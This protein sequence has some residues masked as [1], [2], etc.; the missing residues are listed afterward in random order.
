[1][2]N[3]RKDGTLYEADV[4]VLPMVGSDGAVRH[5]VYVERDISEAGRLERTTRRLMAL[6]SHNLKTPL[7]AIRWQAEMLR[8]GDV[9]R[10]SAPQ[11]ECVEDILGGI[12]RTISMVEQWF[13]VTKMDLGLYAFQNVPGDLN[14]A[15]RRVLDDLQQRIEQEGVTV[16]C[17]PGASP[18]QVIADSEALDTIVH[19]LLRNAVKYNR[20]GGTVDIDTRML[21]AHSE[22]A[23]KT[24]SDPRAI[25]SVRDS[26]IGIPHNEQGKV[27]HEFFHASNTNTTQAGGAGLGLYLTYALVQKLGGDIWYTSTEQGSHFVV[28]LPTSDTDTSGLKQVM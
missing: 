6:T 7:A 13:D 14:E 3:K 11:K 9:G 5:C 23:G 10:L 4:Q 16:R 28:A 24:F 21:E 15:V 17:T 18:C 22:Y 8:D 26:G 27:F 25:L 12:T 1:M 20:I 2:R 19:T